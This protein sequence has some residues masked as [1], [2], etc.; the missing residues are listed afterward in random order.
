MWPVEWVEI[1]WEYTID[2]KVETE[3]GKIQLNKLWMKLCEIKGSIR[4]FYKKD[5]FLIFGT[6]MMNPYPYDSSLNSFPSY[7]LSLL[8]WGERKYNIYHL[9]KGCKCLKM[10]FHFQVSP[11]RLKMLCFYF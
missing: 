11:I 5:L 1:N 4:V 7:Y 3:L 2:A 10:A 9:C 8:I 6:C